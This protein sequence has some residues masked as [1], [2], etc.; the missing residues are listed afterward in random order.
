MMCNTSSLLE[1]KY[2]IKLAVMIIASNGALN[3]NIFLGL[4]IVMLRFSISQFIV[5]FLCFKVV[6]PVQ[7]LV[8]ISQLS[9]YVV[10]LFK[11]ILILRIHVTSFFSLNVLFSYLQS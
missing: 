2:Y 9:C 6:R 1:D 5:F 4:P 7:I 3:A 11:L 8:E 10:V